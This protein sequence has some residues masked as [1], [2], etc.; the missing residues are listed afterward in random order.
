[1]TYVPAIVVAGLLLFIA[2]KRIA[3]DDERLPFLA[4]LSALSFVLMMIAIPLPGGTSAHLSGIA[5]LAILFGPWSA[6]SAAS[7]VL[8]VEALFFGEGGVS[9]LG[10][11]ILAI[12]FMESFLGYYIFKLFEKKRETLGLFLAPLVAVVSAAA[13]I[14]LILGLQSLIVSSSGEQLFF[15][16]SISS[17]LPAIIVPHLFIGVAEGLITVVI[18]RY[19]KKNFGVI[20]EKEER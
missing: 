12:A 15:P 8:I 1:M 5:L 14:A 20:F 4:S 3:F 11:N 13:F 16:F 10:I 7:L 9:T 17:T 18:Y 6:F 2:S 19:L